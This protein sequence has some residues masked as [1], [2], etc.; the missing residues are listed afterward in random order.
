[1]T[2][3]GRFLDVF[4]TLVAAAGTVPVIV[5]AGVA[6]TVGIGEVADF[7]LDPALPK[8]IGHDPALPGAVGVPL[9]VLDGAAAAAAEISAERCDPFRA[10]MLDA[11]QLPAVGVIGHGLRFDGL[12]AE[13]VRHIHGLPTGK[14]DAVAAM[15]DMIDGEMLSHG[16]RR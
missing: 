4:F 6:A 15:T 12:A 3:A 16:A 10:G 11:R 14:G 9:P 7:A 8:C 13:R 2:F 1:M 5:T